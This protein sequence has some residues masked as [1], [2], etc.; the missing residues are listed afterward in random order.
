M[1]K[2][3]SKQ[4]FPSLCEKLKFFNIKIGHLEMKRKSPT[5]TRKQINS[6]TKRVFGPKSINQSINM[7][8]GQDTRQRVKR[9]FL[10]QESLLLC[11]CANLTK[12]LSLITVSECKRHLYR[13]LK[14]NCEFISVFTLPKF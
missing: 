11:F 10:N 12:I 6:V 7:G 8:V 4:D 2:S 13:F 3:L 14:T 9:F 5:D 1:H